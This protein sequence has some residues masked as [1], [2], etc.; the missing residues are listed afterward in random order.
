MQVKIDG[1]K[2][3][4]NKSVVDSIARQSR[5]T[6]QCFSFVDNREDNTRQIR[7]LTGD[8]SYQFPLRQNKLRCNENTRKEEIIQC[9]VGSLIQRKDTVE[10][11]LNK[12]VTYVEYLERYSHQG[13]PEYGKRTRGDVEA[14][15]E[16][17]IKIYNALGSEELQKLKEEN[18]NW[19]D[20][21]KYHSSGYDYNLILYHASHLHFQPLNSVSYEEGI[22]E[23]HQTHL[24][25][26]LEDKVDSNR[27]YVTLYYDITAKF[28]RAGRVM[29][30]NYFGSYA[31]RSGR[32]TT[33]H[34]LQAPAQR[35][36]DTHDVIST[37]KEEQHYETFTDHHD[38]AFDSEVAVF[39]DL[40]QMISNDLRKSGIPHYTT[41]GNVNLFTDRA[42]CNSCTVLAMQFQNDW[43]VTVNVKHGGVDD[44]KGYV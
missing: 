27:N 13:Y 42:T 39:E 40:S 26:A 1:E 34:T 25:P 18:I 5:N 31:G 24:V 17:L 9:S 19:G 14:F 37:D 36:F 28:N 43:G 15:R 21:P 2:T 8:N 29:V 4:K 20:V 12:I 11:F 16:E 23:Y 30:F 38:R 6:K 44:N 10:F 7:L 33:T 32:Y 3:S 41:F 22:Y 35:G